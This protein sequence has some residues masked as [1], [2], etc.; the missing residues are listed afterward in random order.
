MKKTNAKFYVTQNL[1]YN[2]NMKKIILTGSNGLIGSKFKQLFSNKY[3]VVGFDLSNPTNS[4]DI[5]NLEVLK[6]N[7]QENKDAMAVIHMAA[8]TNVNKA[9]EETNNKD[10]LTYQV[11]VIGTR[12][13]ANFCREFDIPLI[14]ISTAY[15]FDGK[16]P[17]FYLE[18]DKINPIEWY[19]QTKAYAEE[20]VQKNLNNYC[21]LRIDQ[22]FRLD[23]F[24]KKDMLAKIILGIENQILYP[25][26]NNHYFG[27]TF[28]D[29]FCQVLDFFINNLDK[30][31]I[32]NASS[33]EKWSDY[34]FANLVNQ[35]LKTNYQIKPGD[36]KEYLKNSVRPYQEN[37]ALNI[38]KLKSVL[39]FKL[40]SIEDVLGEVKKE[41]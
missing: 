6:K 27:P 10:G 37:T 28:I 14:H 25:Q 19:G 15:V 9:F 3:D 8:F 26:F 22:P 20:E 5:T 32:Y 34:Q 23:E 31:G 41:V 16:N 29:D 13:I 33:G 2:K 24:K 40:R 30:T 39:N 7:F 21:I 1:L 36:L 11:N 35:N 17:D 38:D 18:T 12:N 4:V